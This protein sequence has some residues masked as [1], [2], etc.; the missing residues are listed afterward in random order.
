MTRAGRCSVASRDVPVHALACL[1]M[2]TTSCPGH[3]VFLLTWD[4]VW[5]V[6][7]RVVRL[8]D[9]VRGRGED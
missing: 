5:R 8:D 4:R 3:V 6:Q 2:V 9:M 1:A 7:Q